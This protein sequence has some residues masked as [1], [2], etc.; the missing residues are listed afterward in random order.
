MLGSQSL[1]FLLNRAT[2]SF[3]SSSRHEITLGNNDHQ[4]KALSHYAFWNQQKQTLLRSLDT[5]SISNL[6]GQRCT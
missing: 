2:K 6:H 3:R 5:L 4:K 1:S